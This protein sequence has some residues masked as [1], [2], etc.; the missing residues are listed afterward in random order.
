[1]SNDAMNMACDEAFPDIYHPDDLAG[2]ATLRDRHGAFRTG[3]TA[4]IQ[5]IVERLRSDA[6]DF[7][8]Y[9]L[10]HYPN[11]SNTYK[12]FVCNGFNDGKDAIIALITED[13]HGK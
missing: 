8:A 9:W 10:E 12:P 13:A 3:Y 4:A 2:Q 1:M 6:P 5:H 7:E 11:T